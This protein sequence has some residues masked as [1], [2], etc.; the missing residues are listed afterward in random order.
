MYQVAVALL[1]S[2]LAIPAGTATDVVEPTTGAVAA[3]GWSSTVLGTTRPS[4]HS[5][6]GRRERR[7][8]LLSPLCRHICRQF[9]TRSLSQFRLN[10]V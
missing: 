4:N 10:I 1:G 5:N 7:P 6:A 2:T 3:R 9:R 8:L